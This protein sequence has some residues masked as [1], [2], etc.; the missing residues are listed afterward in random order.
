VIA[1]F[2]TLKKHVGNNYLVN[3]MRGRGGRLRK[4]RG[5]TVTVDGRPFAKVKSEKEYEVLLEKL[6]KAKRKVRLV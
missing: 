1:I 2:D 3:D 4:Q 5:F 6:R